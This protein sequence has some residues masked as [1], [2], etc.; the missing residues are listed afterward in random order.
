MD[1]KFMKIHFWSTVLNV[2]CVPFSVQYNLL[3]LFINYA[4]KCKLGLSVSEKYNTNSQ[5]ACNLLLI[6]IQQMNVQTTTQAFL[7]SR[8][9][10][11]IRYTC[12]RRRCRC[13]F[14]FSSIGTVFRFSVL[15]FHC[16]LFGCFEIKIWFI[17]SLLLFSLSLLAFIRSE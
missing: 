10:I 17:F 1:A 6:S 7:E 5:L 12:N 3:L 16:V 15:D 11:Y 14:S 4:T 2:I 8:S 9:R 13:R